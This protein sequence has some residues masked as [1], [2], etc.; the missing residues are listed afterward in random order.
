MYALLSVCP[1]LQIIQTNLPVLTKFDIDITSLE[2]TPKSC[3]LCLIIDNNNK[4]CNNYD[5]AYKGYKY[6]ST[7]I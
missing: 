2:T 4:D 3:L 6:G 5:L 7:R 1:S